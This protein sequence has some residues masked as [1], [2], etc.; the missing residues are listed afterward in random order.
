MFQGL[1]A[2][3]SSA[4]EHVVSIGSKVM[5]LA[6]K[7]SKNPKLILNHEIA[8]S[9]RLI[10]CFIEDI[11]SGINHPEGI[12]YKF[13]YILNS[14]N[15]K[16]AGRIAA[17]YCEGFLVTGNIR[18]RL[19]WSGASGRAGR[20]RIEISPGATMQLDVCAMLYLNPIEFNRINRTFY[21]TDR[22]STLVSQL[23]ISQAI[24]P[25]ELG[26]QSPPSLNKPIRVTQYDIEVNYKS[27]D[28]LRMPV[29]VNS[30]MNDVGIFISLRK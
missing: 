30:K 24:S 8:I 2:A 29:L 15:I 27:T 26:I 14:L 19:P 7:R 28:M 10:H 21:D 23:G 3:V 11:N 25:T 17:E 13:P 1:S 16:N 5:Y 6:G 9:P 20:A 4:T 18:E 22:L 12:G